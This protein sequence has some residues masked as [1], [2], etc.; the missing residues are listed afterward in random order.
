MSL[1][2]AQE[3]DG[4]AVDAE[5]NPVVR[6]IPWHERQ[7]RFAGF[8]RLRSNQQCGITVRVQDHPEF[9]ATVKAAPQRTPAK[10]EPASSSK[11]PGKGQ[12]GAKPD[13]SEPYHRQQQSWS[14]R[15]WSAQE[16]QEWRNGWNQ[17]GWWS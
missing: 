8:Q 12:K 7:E 10:S 13:R 11:G 16:W 9:A 2:K 4:I 1:E 6:P 15:S 3:M 17:G 14:S 5:V